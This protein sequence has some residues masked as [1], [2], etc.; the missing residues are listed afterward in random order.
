M[1]GDAVLDDL[2]ARGLLHD[3]TDPAELRSM[4]A[5]GPVTVYCGFDPTADS[6]HVGNL[7]SLLLLRR[8]QLHGHRPIALAGGATGMIGDPSGRDAER[9]LLDDATIDANLAAIRPQLER[10]LDFE[11]GPT[12]ARLVDNRD[13]TA[14][15]SVLEF[16]RD[17]GKHVTVNTMLAKD[18]VRSRLGR[19]SGISF[20][21]FSYMLLQANDF[22][23]LHRDH[24]CRLQVA[25]SDQW[26]NIVAGIDLVRRTA[27]ATVHGLTAPLITGS[28]GRKFGKSTGG[29]GLWLDPDRTSPYRL[30]QYFMQT[31]DR[32]VEPW[33]LRLTLLG[34]DEVR[35]AAAAHAEAPGRR[36]GQALLARTICGFVHGDEAAA[37]AAQV[38]AL[39]FGGSPLEASPT[40]FEHLAAEIP[41]APVLPG[42]DGRVEVAGLLAAAFG[43]SKGQVR[44]NLAGYTI[45]G[46]RAPELG[47][48]V[49]LE[50]LVHG[51]WALLRK[52]KSNYV[53]GARAGAGGGM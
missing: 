7:Q 32:D 9:S 44:K 39:L 11:S 2:A 1:G 18:S 52:G 40:T 16:L 22:A 51:R 50:H 45:N 4:L 42:A 35:A 33:L 31:D 12:Q 6:L 17:V 25:G 5:A 49:G 20:T 36:D 14:P 30:Y 26:G 41:T 3:H 23:V 13:W 43:D 10:F 19:D 46:V 34:V 21:E 53:L 24:D 8:F 28:D 15:M 38:S 48:A 29:G 37:A 47:D 27:G